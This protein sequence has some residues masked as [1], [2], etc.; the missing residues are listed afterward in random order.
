MS[1]IWGESTCFQ[2]TKV[3]KQGILKSNKSVLQRRKNQQVSYVVMSEDEYINT[4]ED[5]IGG[6][7]LQRI[8]FVNKHIYYICHIIY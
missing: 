5:A 7:V 1:V 4:L 2:L 3:S 8:N 6:Y